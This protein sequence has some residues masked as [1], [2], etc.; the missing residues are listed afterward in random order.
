MI[1]RNKICIFA[2][3]TSLLLFAIIFKHL[4]VGKISIL[5]PEHKFKPPPLEPNPHN[6]SGISAADDPHPNIPEVEAPKTGHGHYDEKVGEKV[7]TLEEWL[8]EWEETSELQSNNWDGS[9]I[10]EVCQKTEWRGDLVFECLKDPSM[11]GCSD[12]IT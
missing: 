7:W 3:I 4:A 2:L 5:R 1:L 10:R 12:S 6:T 9:A 8:N 11:L